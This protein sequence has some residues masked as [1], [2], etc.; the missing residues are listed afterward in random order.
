MRLSR[1]V[2][3]LVLVAIASSVAACGGSDDSPAG[4]RDRTAPTQSASLSLPAL[5]DCVDATSNDRIEAVLTQGETNETKYSDDLGALAPDAVVHEALAA[6][7]WLQ[8]VRN[9]EDSNDLVQVGLVEVL[10]FE[11]GDAAKVAAT[12]TLRGTDDEGISISKY[13]NVVQA[14]NLLVIYNNEYHEERGGSTA[15][16]GVRITAQR[17]LSKI[18]SSV[19]LPEPKRVLSDPV[20]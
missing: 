14:D 17:C 8:I 5:R 1:L 19:T 12:T 2:P 6:D 9:R 11:S 4:T 15:K 16:L 18:G 7:G 20:E 10:G 3:S 13:Y